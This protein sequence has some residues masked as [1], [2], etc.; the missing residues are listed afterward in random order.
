MQINLKL[1]KLNVVSLHNLRVKKWRKKQ[2]QM[3]NKNYFHC[4]TNVGQKL[5][6]VWIISMLQFYCLMKVQMGNTNFCS[7]NSYS[8]DKY[9]LSKHRYCFYFQTLVV[10]EFF[11]V[12]LN[13]LYNCNLINKIEN[14]RFLLMIIAYVEIN[15]KKKK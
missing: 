8:L 11:S 14:F 13:K 10:S 7:V 15:S 9:F 2:R 1:H 3:G 4:C 5:W 12:P 6:D